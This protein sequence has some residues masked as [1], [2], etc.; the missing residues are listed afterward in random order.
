MTTPAAPT[1]AA[2]PARTRQFD[3]VICFGGEDWWYH[4]RGHYDMQM[5]RRIAPRAPVLYINSIGMR[6][7]RIAEGAMFLTR[8]ARKAR[9][10]RRGRVRVEPGFTVYS[11]LAAPGRPGRRVNAALL[12][13]QVRRAARAAGVTRPLVWVACPPAVTAL[14]RLGPAAVV[15]QRTD[16]YEQFAGV[17]PD[18]IAG[19]D[20]DLKARADLTVFCASRLYEDES[21]ACREAFYADHGVDADR[22][23]NA[24]MSRAYPED[25]AALRRPRVGFVGGIDSHT[26]DPALFLS[27]ARALP[28]VTFALVGACSL[29]EGWCDAPNVRLLGQK[30][31]GDVAGYMAACDALIMPW[32]RS[33]WIDACNPVK[34]KEYLAVGRPI[35]TTPFYELKHYEGLVRVADTPE[36]FARQ[37]RGALDDPGDAEA[38]RR[39]VRDQT[40]DAKADAVLARLAAL[41]ITPA[42]REPT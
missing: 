31:Y 3:G 34:L 10:L 28:D 29:P 36:A 5:M 35:V 21:R 1:P 19:F 27:V 41:G 24:G 26:F 37:V 9:S 20:R 30:P 40:W 38:R 16:R 4:N 23:I 13:W 14:D 7:P 2:S 25:I 39:R 6:T 8:V 17:D 12:P 15:Y 22:F 42:S 33:K 11:P 18:L 32:N